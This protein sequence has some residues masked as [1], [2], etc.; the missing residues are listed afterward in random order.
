MLPGFHSA[1][2]FIEADS[3]TPTWAALYDIESVDYLK[4]AAYT[5]LAKTRSARETDVL[6]RLAFLE[7]RIYTLNEAAP[8]TVN[9]KFAGYAE[10]EGPLA[11]TTLV[12]VSVDV[13]PEHEAEFHKWYDEEHVPLLSKVPGWLRSRRYILADS[14]VSGALP[15]ASAAYKPPLKFLA[16]HDY[17]SPDGLNGPEWKT[18]TSTP[19]RNKVFENVK[20]I[21]RRIFKVYKTFA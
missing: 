1:T 6:S 18:A 11:P 19:W 17:S 9:A 10:G 13:P 20:G 4:T 16:V 8:T 14:G 21:E 15:G 2:R 7:R 12:A 5:D 3:M